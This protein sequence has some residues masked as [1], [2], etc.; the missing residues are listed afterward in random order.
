MSSKTRPALFDCF[1]F[2]NELDLLEI[3]LTE[4]DKLVDHFVLV[5]ATRTHTG[6]PKPLY[7]AE[8]KSRFASFL[9]RIIHV[10]VDDLPDES[11]LD[12]WIPE[13]RQRH[14][15]VRGLDSAKPGDR[16]LVSDLDEIP[17]APHLREALDQFAPDR[18]LF[19][20]WC[21]TY[22]HRLNM[23]VAGWNH[24]LS[25]VLLT[26]RHLRS[27]QDL[28]HLQIFV[29][30]R[31]WIRPVAGAMAVP[32]VIKRLGRVLWPQIV[33]SGAWHFSCMGNSSQLQA[34]LAAYAH[35]ENNLPGKYSDE[36]L[37]AGL[38]A[39]RSPLCPALPLVKED[40]TQ[41]PRAVRENP[42]RYEHLLF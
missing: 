15:I 20:F 26:R 38:R 30:K 21:D 35:K 31:Q 9:D 37:E 11:N 41:M 2:F 6:F 32:R 16:I 13:G 18:R 25:P 28:R 27:P 3:R 39:G 5:E 36:V 34:K 12:P 33:W 17:R 1:T 14:C 10:V 8:H 22:V 23:R 19:A 29:S 40:I 42:Q 7:F 24:R 4:L